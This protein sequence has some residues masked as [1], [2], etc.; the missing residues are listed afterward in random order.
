MSAL[1]KLFS[2]LWPF[3]CRTGSSRLVSIHKPGQLLDLM[4]SHGVIRVS[5]NLDI[6]C[7]IPKY[8]GDLIRVFRVHRNLSVLDGSFN[9]GGSLWVHGD[10]W[11]A[12]GLAEIEGNL[13]IFGTSRSETGLT[14]KGNLTHYGDF[15]SLNYLCVHENLDS[16]GSFNSTSTVAIGGSWSCEADVQVVGPYVIVMDD[17]QWRRQGAPTLPER[18]YID[19]DCTDLTPSWVNE[20]LVDLDFY[21]D[22]MTVPKFL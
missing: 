10:L 6:L 16:V 4:D 21:G 9:V 13:E 18:T 22:S 12:A 17:L 8:V 11:L 20:V 3:R 15:R 2:L 5:G 7:A 14:V 19:R 1:R